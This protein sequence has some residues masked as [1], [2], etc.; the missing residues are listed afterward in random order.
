MLEKVTRKRLT[1]SKET[2]QVLCNEFDAK[3]VAVYNALAGR[4]R[5]KKAQAICNRAVE[6][7]A[8][9]SRQVVWRGKLDFES[10]AK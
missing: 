8:A 9:V 5:S 7:G 6:L 4:S 10:L 1:V 2:F 3:K